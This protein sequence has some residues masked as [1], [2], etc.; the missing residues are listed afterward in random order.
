V[1]PETASAVHV[2]RREGRELAEVGTVGGLGRGERIY[3][4]RFA[5]PVGYVVTFRETDPVY[6]VDLRDPRRPKVT[7]ELKIPGYSAYLHP[8]DDRTLIGVGQDATA[9]GRRLGTQVSVFDVADPARPRRVSTYRVPGSGSEAEFDPHAFLYWPR[10]G[11][12]VLP[13]TLHDTG[14]APPE[15]KMRWPSTSGALVL[16]LRDGKLVERGTVRHPAVYGADPAIRRS[17]V[18]GGTLWT[19]SAA[20]ARADTVGGLAQQ[21]WLPFG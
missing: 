10:T 13:L 5:G 1:A 3:A 17:L 6:T 4:V 12:V 21:G 2:L 19:I 15:E 14:F 16:S 18:I 20:G 7:G 9:Q 8:V 11:T